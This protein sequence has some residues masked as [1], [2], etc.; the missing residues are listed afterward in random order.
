M[1]FSSQGITDVRLRGEARRNIYLVLKEALHNTVKHAEATR[2][3]ISFEQSRFLQIRY[4]DNGK[5]F[6]W[7]TVRPFANGLVNMEKRMSDVM[8][9]FALETD[10]G[11]GITLTVPID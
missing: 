4:R 11:V 3:M 10:N 7:S 2:V 9:T 8:G 1:D 5:G 6:D